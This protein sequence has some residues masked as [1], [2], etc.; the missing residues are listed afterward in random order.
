MGIRKAFLSMIRAYPGGWDAM[1]A[2]LGY[3]RQGLENR[4]YERKGQ[5][6]S[7]NDSLQMQ[8]FSGTTLLAE[9]IAQISGGAFVQF[10]PSGSHDR[11]ELLDKFNEL[12]AELG[13]LSNKFR[14]A[15]KDD[16]IEGNERAELEDTGQQ[17]HRTVSELLALTFRVYCRNESNSDCEVH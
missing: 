16:V 1:A 8:E 3:S 10:P 14:D 15:T 5:S 11:G 17:I 13:D 7:L 6:L 9:S 12:Y 4:I 2:A